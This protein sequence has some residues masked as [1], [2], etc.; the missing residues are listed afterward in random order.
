MACSKSEARFCF[1]CRF[2]SQEQLKAL[3]EA[4]WVACLLCTPPAPPSLSALMH[5]VPALCGLWHSPGTPA[6]ASGTHLH[7]RHPPVPVGGPPGHPFTPTPPPKCTH[8]WNAGAF[9]LQDFFWPKDERSHWIDVPTFH[10]RPIM[11]LHTVSSDLSKPFSPQ[12]PRIQLFE[13]LKARSF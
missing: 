12:T 2:L 9:T 3:W 10:S 8:N 1:M 7:L 5:P 11:A 4:L 6:C 13:P